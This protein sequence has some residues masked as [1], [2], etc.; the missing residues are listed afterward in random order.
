MHQEI[1]KINYDYCIMIN[2]AQVIRLTTRGAQKEFR[3]NLNS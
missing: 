2:I 3:S 1:T